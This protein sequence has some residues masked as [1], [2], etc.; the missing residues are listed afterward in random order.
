M[1]RVVPCE[2]RG[3]L[4]LAALALLTACSVGPNYV[5]PTAP[6]PAVYKELGQWKPAEPRDTLA[7]GPWWERWDDDE[8]SRLEEQVTAA[9]QDLVA[10]E[11]RF[12][13]ARALVSN[14]R[15][16]WWPVVT[17][18]VSATRSRQSANLGTQFASGRTANDYAMPIEASWEVDVW[19]RI[20]RNVESSEASAQASAADVEATRL[21]L[22]AA[23]ASDY[24]QLRALD[25]ERQLFDETVGNFERSLALTQ[26]RYAQGVASGADV[27][28]AETQLE[29]A[30]AQSIDLGVARAQFEHAIATLVGTPAGDYSIAPTPLD[31]T[32]PEIPTGVPSELL[33]R[34][35][36]VA[37]AERDAAAA[38]AQI[39]VAQAAYYPTVSLGASGGFTSSHV[40]DWFTWPSRVWSLGPSVTETVFDGGK[41]GALTAQAR[42][43]YDERVAAYRGSVLAAFQNVE[44][45]LAAARLLEEEG[46]HQADAVAAALKAVRIATDQYKAGTIS[47]LDV[48]TVQAA[49]LNNQ[50]TEIDVL[51]RRMVASV[52]LVQA[53][54][55][56]WS[57]DDLPSRADVRS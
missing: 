50:R 17:I 43:A 14:A 51:G 27:A 37:A 11:A 30:R 57:M 13:Q 19:G 23:L 25:A 34:R 48:V 36:D 18:G 12:R 47:Y 20:R 3:R 33:E 54:G 4:A 29:S 31:A 9:N 35:P 24:F 22:Q 2:A 49:A 45:Q 52:Q 32:P 10:A 16:D 44:D 53:L 42:A 6:V 39:G 5:R 8:L 15:A 41:R 28:Q 26:K 7:R 1:Y 55:G 46:R 21:S 38:N 40:Q 56:G